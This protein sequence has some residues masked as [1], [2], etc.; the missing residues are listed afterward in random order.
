MPTLAVQ[1]TI[2]DYARWRSIFDKNKPLRDRAGLKNVLVYRDAD[3]P[4][5]LVVWSETAD[6]AKAREALGGP[7]CRNAMQEAGV[8]GPPKVHVLAPACA[9]LA[10]A[11]LG[12]VTMQG[13][14]RA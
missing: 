9:E 12:A 6:P 11:L 4:H 7:D 3:D 1:I 2:D 13:T 10:P 14:A 8:V 5:Q